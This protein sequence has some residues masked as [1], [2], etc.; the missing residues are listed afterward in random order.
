MSVC[1]QCGEGF[2]DLSRTSPRS[3]CYE[4]RPVEVRRLRSMVDSVVVDS[5]GAFTLEHFREWA[6][7]LELDT[8]EFWVLEPFQEAFVADWL[9]GFT[10]CWLIVPEGNG[11]TT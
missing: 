5:S 6:S 10:E 4:C 3:Y 9:A 8:G 7:G 1:A 2:E 11:K